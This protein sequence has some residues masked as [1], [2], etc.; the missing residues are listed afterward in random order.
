MKS[1]PQ[2]EFNQLAN[3]IVTIIKSME[4]LVNVARYSQSQ[5]EAEEI[6]NRLQTCSINLNKKIADAAVNICGIA[7]KDKE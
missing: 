7:M 3:E 6:C 5:V 4:G 2:S 1:K